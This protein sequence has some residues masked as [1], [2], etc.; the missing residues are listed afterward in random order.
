MLQFNSP[1]FVFDKVLKNVTLIKSFW[2]DWSYFKYG[3][4][5]HMYRILNKYFFIFANACFWTLLFYV[6]VRIFN[7]SLNLVFT[8]T[9]PFSIYEY[10]RYVVWMCKI[11]LFCVLIL[12]LRDLVYLNYSLDL[13]LSSHYSRML[14]KM[15]GFP[16]SSFILSFIWR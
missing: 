11:D 10:I 1:Q 5:A 9:F 7:I 12:L 14:V 6:F 13:S 15:N 8:F 3:V 16:I 4:I 2:V